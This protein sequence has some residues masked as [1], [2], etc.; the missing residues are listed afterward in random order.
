MVYHTAGAVFSA[1]SYVDAFGAGAENKALDRLKN[2]E[3]GR[4][5]RE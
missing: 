1:L 3:Q 2:I 5:N 4:R